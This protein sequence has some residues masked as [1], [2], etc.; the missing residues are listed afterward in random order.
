MW[1]MPID[2]SEC[3]WTERQGA[4]GRDEATHDVLTGL[5]CIRIYTHWYR[6]IHVCVLLK[7]NY[8]YT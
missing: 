6:R 8:L 4:N 5:Y 7:V 1:P 2:N 3:S